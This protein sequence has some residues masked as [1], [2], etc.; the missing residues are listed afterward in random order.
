MPT[1]TG[2]PRGRTEH[3]RSTRGIL[4]RRTV[5]ARTRGATARKP[6]AQSAPRVR[7]GRR[8]DTARI[9]A[10]ASSRRGRG[11]DD[12][13]VDVHRELI[14]DIVLESQAVEKSLTLEHGLGCP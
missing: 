6:A 3:R 1:E 10:D 12:L 8:K 11:R 7:G 13:A 9:P 4:P 14:S 2:A 5:R